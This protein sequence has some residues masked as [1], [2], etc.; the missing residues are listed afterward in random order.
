MVRVLVSNHSRSDDGE[1]EEEVNLV[2]HPMDLFKSFYSR[3]R[4]KLLLLLLLPQGVKVL[5][6]ISISDCN[7]LSTLSLSSI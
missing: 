5:S 7:L 1:E 2:Q 3:F 4:R 6:T